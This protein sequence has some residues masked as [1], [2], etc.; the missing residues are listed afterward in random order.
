MTFKLVIQD[1][2]KLFKLFLFTVMQVKVKGHQMNGLLA[3]NREIAK[4]D[5]SDT[6]GWVGDV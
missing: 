1:V 2:S 5:M 4:M 6:F 3:S